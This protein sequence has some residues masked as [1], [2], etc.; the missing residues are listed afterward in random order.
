M[1]ATLA[2]IRA[3]LVTTID[4][5][6]TSDP[7]LTIEPYWK[8]RLNLPCVVVGLDP[9]DT[10]DYTVAYR[11]GTRAWTLWVHVLVSAN[12]LP[13]AQIELD[14]FISANQS[15]PWSVPDAIWASRENQPPGNSIGLTGV[16][17]YAAR[18]TAYGARFE[19]AAAIPHLG[20][21]LVCPTLVS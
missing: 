11:R 6:V 16:D 15:D 3:A 21:V 20:A 13:K 2:Q 19:Q 4:A 17:L 18:V 5:G 10:G 12:D 9:S 7:S 1:A 8:D 14:R